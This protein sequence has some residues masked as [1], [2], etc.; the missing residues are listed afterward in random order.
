LARGIRSF[1]ALPEVASDRVGLAAWSVGTGGALSA[2]A[3]FPD[4]PVVAAAMFAPTCA[5][6]QGLPDGPGQPPKVPSWTLAGADL[7]WLRIHGEKLIP[8]LIKNELLDRFPGHER[9]QALHM[10]KSYDAGLKGLKLMAPEMIPVEKIA[11]PLLICSGDSDALW[12]SA[13]MSRL[14][15]QRRGSRPDDQFEFYSGGHMF[16]APV[17]PT[18]VPWNDA[19]YFGGTAVENADQYRDAWAAQLA[20]WQK[21]LGS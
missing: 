19:F 18:T 17:T 12:P 9:P 7:P 20:F 21:H 4:L 10:R 5:I 14:L 1:A 8:E 13:P 16:R 3:G 11:S 6:W 15:Q 2:L